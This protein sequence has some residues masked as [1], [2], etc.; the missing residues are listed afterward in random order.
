VD[1]AVEPLLSR[2]WVSY[3]SDSALFVKQYN[4]K[5]IEIAGNKPGSIIIAPDIYAAIDDSLIVSYIEKTTSKN[6]LILAKI[7][8]KNKKTPEYFQLS[9]NSTLINARIYQ[10]KAQDKNNLAVL[11]S[12]TN[13]SQI[14][15]HY[16]DVT[17]NKIETKDIKGL[18]GENI[19][20]LTPVFTDKSVYFCYYKIN[21]QGKDKSVAISEFDKNNFNL[22]NAI[23]FDNIEGTSFIYG[24]T[25]KNT[26][27][28]IFKS[29]EKDQF[30]LN[31][32]RL[33]DNKWQYNNLQEFD[34]LDVARL[35]YH[36][37]DNGNIII[38]LSAEDANK[39]KQRI[40]AVTSENS[41]ETFQT[42]RI[43]R[44][45]FDNTR[46]WLPGLIVTGNHV[47]TVWEDMRDIRGGIYYNISKDM[48][49]IWQK[50]AFSLSESKYYAMR[51][52]ISQKN[53]EIFVAWQQYKD[54][55]KQKAELILAR[56]NLKE[57]E[58]NP[59]KEL[60]IISDIRKKK[61]LVNSINEYWNAMINKDYNK[62]Y[63]MHDPFFR[64]KISS[65]IFTSKT[66]SMVYN[67]FKLEEVIILGN[68]ASLKATINYE[69]P[70]LDISGKETSISK[71]DA[72]IVDVWL[73]LDGFWYRKYV[74]PLTGASAVSY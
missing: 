5:P 2:D 73:Y 69:A 24:F 31:I 22:I 3:I 4:S 49:K 11:E 32:A 58:N 17:T 8:S 68:E 70:D 55:T 72:E 43:D 42:Q 6:N 45:E 41:G 57:L 23:T 15:L 12:S 28:F 47:I 63:L 44:R 35:D 53:D 46:S 37:Q 38:V 13:S 34:G 67:K 7:A 29:F 66:G 48:G 64:A 1:V 54:D 26:P 71:K 51:P 40:F 36:V 20:N 52:A 60:I 30:R 33:K 50:N 10:D 59:K 65:E 25:V 27:F 56:T 39:F 74:D 62:V 18:T 19:F 61:N 21:N 14:K 9:S 16:F